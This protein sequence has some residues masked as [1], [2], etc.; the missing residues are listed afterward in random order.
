M[1]LSLFFCRLMFFME[2]IVFFIIMILEEKKKEN[3]VREVYNFC[4]L[5]LGNFYFYCL[6][7]VIVNVEIGDF[8]KLM[9]RIGWCCVLVLYSCIWWYL[10]LIVILDCEFWLGRNFMFVI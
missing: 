2:L 9:F 6:L 7:L 4:N 8:V 3:F 10:V 1:L 5:I